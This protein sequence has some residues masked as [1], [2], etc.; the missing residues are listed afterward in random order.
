[1]RLPEGEKSIAQGRGP[2]GMRVSWLEGASR[3]QTKPS[4]ELT[5]QI[6]SRKACSRRSEMFEATGM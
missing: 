1:M 3:T 5:P 2:T 4:V 6:S